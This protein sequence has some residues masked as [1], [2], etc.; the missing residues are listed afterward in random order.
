MRGL[1]KKASLHPK[2]SDAWTMRWAV[3]CAALVLVA[4]G[5][6]VGAQWDGASMETRSISLNPASWDI[7]F[8]PTMPA[9]P[10][11]AEGGGWYFDFPVCGDV[12]NCSVHY[13][14]TPISLTLKEGQAIKA[15]FTVTTSGSPRFIYQTDGGCN[16]PANT[17][18]FL[19]RGLDLTYDEF[20]RWWAK[21]A[22]FT[23]AAGQATLI[24]TLA[25]DQWSSVEGRSGNDSFAAKAGFS[26]AI[27]NV[28]RIG[29][30]FGGGCNAGH[31]VSVTG[32]TARLTLTQ[33]SVGP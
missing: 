21:T 6:G 25:P 28:S 3:S 24:A 20:D 30:T 22:S 15:T 27:K 14:N 31:G 2:A 8:S 1:C 9:H 18:L 7:L 26:K 32:G 13:V 29:L 23:L 17:R 16:T 19:Q 12:Q 33:F 11:P 4:A 5:G 10:S